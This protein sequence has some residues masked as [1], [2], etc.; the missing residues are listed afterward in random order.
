M[1]REVDLKEIS[2]G[3]L[4]GLNDMVKAD[5]RD[6]R[7]CHACCQNMGQSVIL[8]PLDVFRIG[9]GQNTCFE[10]LLAQGKLELHVVDQVILPNLK[11]TGSKNCC[12][13]LNE[14]GRCSIHKDRPGLCRLFP[15]GRYY[16]GDKFWYFLQ[17][18]ECKKE[19][20]SKVKVKKWIDV[21]KPQQYQAFILMW[22]SFLKD[23]EKILIGM[24]EEYK[25]QANLFLLN[26]FYIKPY[27][28]PGSF[29][30][31]FGE[32]ISSAAFIGNGSK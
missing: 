20:R 28:E 11:M 16:E 14:E 30:Q 10:E 17:T 32:R 22:H 18:K 1:K 15:L 9:R 4:Y 2:D 21:E 3:K 12:S 19:D 23:M 7:D 13:F 27:E 31:E 29:Y 24:D 6:C 26:L 5:C 25:K 8:D